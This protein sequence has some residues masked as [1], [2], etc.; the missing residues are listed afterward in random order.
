MGVVENISYDRFPRQSKKYLGKEVDV[1]FNYNLYKT[2]KGVIVRD[3]EE[4]P[5]LTIIRLE[6][7]RYVLVTEC[8]YSFD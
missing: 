1:C 6:D 4:S 5:G 7:G 2:I 8:Q 3:D